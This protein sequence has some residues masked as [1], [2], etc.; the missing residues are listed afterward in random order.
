MA[1]DDMNGFDWGRY[2]VGLSSEAALET[3][4]A[5]NIRQREQWDQDQ[6]RIH[7]EATRDI[8]RD[9]QNTS[10]QITRDAAAQ[11]Q[12]LTESLTAQL[13]EAATKGRA[14]EI[15]QMANIIGPILDTAAA[16]AREAVSEAVR[17]TALRLSQPV[18]QVP[19]L[20]LR[21]LVTEITESSK[22]QSRAVRE[23]SP[24]VINV[25]MGPLTIAVENAGRALVAAFEKFANR[26]MIVNAT[27]QLPPPLG[28]TVTIETGPDGT[29]HAVVKP[30]GA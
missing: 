14:E 21:P 12:N 28:A 23:M 18:V 26:P 10:H 7:R 17:E 16:Q 2:G 19:P 9:A 29:K 15:A 3:Q 1:T 11:L 25:D 5:H 13:T 4:E 8:V 27:V 20:D 6:A 24:A 22:R 30:L